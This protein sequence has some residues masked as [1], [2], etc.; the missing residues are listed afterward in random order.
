MIVGHGE[1]GGEYLHKEGLTGDA[2]VIGMT[3]KRL[4]LEQVTLKRKDEEFD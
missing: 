4:L 3:R 1:S 2:K